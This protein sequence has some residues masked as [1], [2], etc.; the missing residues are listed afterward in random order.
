MNE[1]ADA[2]AGWSLPE[3]FHRAAAEIYERSARA[4]ADRDSD[5]EQMLSALRTEPG[6]P[7]ERP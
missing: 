2:F 3:G 5:L 1:I 4:H 7:V 6:T